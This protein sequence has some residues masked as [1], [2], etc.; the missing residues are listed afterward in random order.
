MVFVHGFLHV[1]LHPGNILISLKGQSDFS[2]G[3]QFLL[4]IK[5]KTNFLFSPKWHAKDV[6][7]VIFTQFFWIL[8]SVENWMKFLD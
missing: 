8:G 2:L 4:R 1:D 6:Y 7:F 3:M 5:M